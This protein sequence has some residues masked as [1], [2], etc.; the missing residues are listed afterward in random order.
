MLLLSHSLSQVKITV[1]PPISSGLVVDSH[2]SYIEK[3]TVKTIAFPAQEPMRM[4]RLIGDIYQKMTTPYTGHF[5]MTWQDN[6]QILQIIQADEKV[7]FSNLTATDFIKTKARSIDWSTAPNEMYRLHLQWFD[8]EDNQ[9]YQSELII[10]S[11]KL[12]TYNEA[13]FSQYNFDTL[14]IDLAQGGQYALWLSTPSFNIQFS[15][16]INA[17][18]INFDWETFKQGAVYDALN[19]LSQQEYSTLITN[20]KKTPYYNLRFS[21]IDQDNIPVDDFLYHIESEDGDLTYCGK[22]NKEGMTKVLASDTL[23]TFNSYDDAKKC[24]R[25]NTSPNYTNDY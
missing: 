4:F 21:L 7:Y 16:H 24:P 20:R 14:M 2:N 11:T 10:N 13:L 5:P 3:L 25:L 19:N 22:T 15:D 1:E 17:H 8:A 12:Y 23:R 9:F 18:K 6:E